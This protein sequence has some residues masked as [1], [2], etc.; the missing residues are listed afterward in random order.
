MSTLLLS[1]ILNRYNIAYFLIDDLFRIQ[2]ASE[3]S[4]QYCSQIDKIQDVGRDSLSI[5]LLNVPVGEILPEIIGLEPLMKNFHQTP[6]QGHTISR[7]QRTNTDG[8]VLFFDL[9][10]ESLPLPDSGYLVLLADVTELAQLTQRLATQRNEL[11]LVMNDLKNTQKQI[12]YLLQRFVPR[13]LAEKIISDQE[14]SRQN[15]LP[16]PGAEGQSEATLLFADMRNFSGLIERLPLN[17]AVD[18]LNNCL[19][20]I[21]QAVTLSGGSVVQLVGDMLMASFN[22][23]DPLTDHAYRAAQAALNAQ[24]GLRRL[25]D[26]HEIGYDQPVGFGIGLNS[27]LVASGYLSAGGLYQFALIGDV[28]NVAY[29]LCSRAAAGRV[30]ISHSTSQAIADRAQVVNLGEMHF[31]SRQQRMPVYELLSLREG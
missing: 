19:E 8:K 3:R 25:I 24:H 2:Y 14:K 29:H 27:G 17:L 10:V 6:G 28:T 5:S 20:V 30:V 1:R 16:L 22:A 9:Y 15:R 11:R 26:T 13:N 7:T 4:L 21:A 18:L 12:S 23:P 31:K